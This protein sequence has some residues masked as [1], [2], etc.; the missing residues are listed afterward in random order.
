MKSIFTGIKQAGLTI[1]RSFFS[2]PYARSL[3]S[4][5]R[6]HLSRDGSHCKTLDLG[7]GKTPKNPF[8]A[9]DLFGIDVDY[10]LDESRN[11]LRCD[12][13]MEPLP[14]P[15]RHFDFVTAFDLLEHIPRLMY[16]GRERHYPFIY[17]MSEVYR[18]LKVKGIFLS[19]TP[20]FPRFSSFADPTHVNTITAETFR[21]YFCSP[22]V[23]AERYGFEGRFG[24]VRQAW[25]RE[26]LLTLMR[27]E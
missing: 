10:G 19:D 27:R 5:C 17:L 18:V 15:D 25:Y 14:F 1:Y 20:A 13:G 21:M 24:L 3:D 8:Q 6:P 9:E 23:W 7:C 4:F 22:H 16:R 2:I 11:I 12:L 26:N